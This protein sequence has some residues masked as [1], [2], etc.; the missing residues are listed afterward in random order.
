MTE[1]QQFYIDH[2][3]CYNCG[4][5]NA[6]RGKRFCWRC[7]IRKREQNHAE[8]ES[9]SPEKRKERAQK[10]YE[11]CKLRYESRKA[12]GLCPVCG[13]PNPD[14]RFVSCNACRSKD[15]NRKL[16]RSHQNGVLPS[17]MRGYGHRC[18]LCTREIPLVPGKKLC[19]ECYAKSCEALKKGRQGRQCRGALT[20][21]ITNTLFFR[22]AEKKNDQN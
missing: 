1:L 9:L 13:N 6:E 21:G 7:L 22:K 2:G 8:R 15:R 17:Q 20:W 19:S 16:I 10:K 4:Q 5:K 11:Y 18:Y 12:A 14:R 3:I